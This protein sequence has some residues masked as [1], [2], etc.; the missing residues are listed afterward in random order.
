VDVFLLEGSRDG[1][2]GL[3]GRRPVLRPYALRRC[4]RLGVGRH[5]EISDVEEF[6][7]EALLE[8]IYGKQQQSY[9]CILLSSLGTVVRLK[10]FRL[11]WTASQ[12][13]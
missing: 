5:V 7:E 9:V 1:S 11:G 13:Y 10:C 2:R 3:L 12:R 8:V 6:G 4:Y